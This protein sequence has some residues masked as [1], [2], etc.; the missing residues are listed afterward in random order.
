MVEH[1]S[2]PL[3]GQKYWLH[4]ALAPQ[5]LETLKDLDVLP[6]EVRRPIIYE[7]NNYNTS[8]EIYHCRCSTHSFVTRV[9]SSK[10]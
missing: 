3:F 2:I 5:S 4:R 1:F 9:S 10:P 8:S 6:C 7:S